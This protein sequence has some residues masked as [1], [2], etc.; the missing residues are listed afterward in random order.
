ML[1]RAELPGSKVWI[2][3]EN[4]GFGDY[5]ISTQAGALAALHARTAGSRAAPPS[6]HSMYLS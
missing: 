4:L 6:L 1:I 5:A 2:T 3:E